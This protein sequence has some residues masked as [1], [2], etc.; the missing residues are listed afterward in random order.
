MSRQSTGHRHHRPRSVPK[1]RI[2]L[3]VRL[4]VTFL[5]GSTHNT[6]AAGTSHGCSHLRGLP[7]WSTGRPRISVDGR[8]RSGLGGGGG[9]LFPVHASD[10]WANDLLKPGPGS[11]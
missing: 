7:G 2:L 6:F 1:T 4:A 10:G 5:S 8:S 9:G 3:R 11:P